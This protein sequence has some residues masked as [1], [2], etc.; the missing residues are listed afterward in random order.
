MVESAC[1]FCRIIRG[2]IPARK[3]MEDSECLAFWDIQPQAPVHIL[4]L[5]KQHV[6]RLSEVQES[7][8]ALLGKLLAAAGRIARE[9]KLDSGYRVVVN[10]GPDGGQAVEHLHLHLLGGRK[11][12]WPPG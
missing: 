9:Q 11:M 2:E 5:P 7:G 1:L 6:S 8:A 3:V 10:C 4:I 12:S